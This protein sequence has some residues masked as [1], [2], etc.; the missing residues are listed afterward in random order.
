MNRSH[1][2]VV[3]SLAVAV[4]MLLPVSA[5]VNTH[6]VNSQQFLAAV[7]SASASPS[8]TFDGGSAPPPPFPNFARDGGSAPPPPF[9]NR[10]FDGGSAP[11]PPFPNLARD[12]GSAP[13]P[14]FPNIWGTSALC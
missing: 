13:P 4:V 1:L 11:P 5:G 2:F 9:P 10:G 7:P 3:L 14:P 6:S 8:V 12:G